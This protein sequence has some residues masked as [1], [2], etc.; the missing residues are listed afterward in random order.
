MSIAK[1]VERRAERYATQ[2]LV[3]VWSTTFGEALDMTG[4]RPG[5]LQDRF[6]DHT[7]NEK[8]AVTKRTAGAI[9]DNNINNIDKKKA[10][11]V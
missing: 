5:L 2:V 3:R 4:P 7:C 11:K 9:G 8:D 1:R 6:S 10:Q